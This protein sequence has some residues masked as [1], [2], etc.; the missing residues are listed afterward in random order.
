LLL[1]GLRNPLQ[2]SPAMGRCEVLE[3]LPRLCAR[4][5][6][7]LD[8]WRHV[9]VALAL[10]LLGSFVEA[11]QVELQQPS[12]GHAAFADQLAQPLL[13]QRGPFVPIAP[14]SELL[15][16]LLLV[17]LL[18]DAIDPTEA[19]GLLDGIVI[20]DARL[21]AV[22]LVVDDPDLGLRLTVLLEPG[23]PLV[24]VGDME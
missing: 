3:V 23:A 15:R 18:D 16:E 21:P 11:S 14:R 6:G 1:L 19:Q 22:L 13:V 10:F 5:Q 8:K 24:A 12:L 9:R 20:W 17:D 4:P 7:L 2:V